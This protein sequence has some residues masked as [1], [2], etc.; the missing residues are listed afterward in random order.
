MGA[1][2]PGGNTILGPEA[3]PGRSLRLRGDGQ[4]GR[5]WFSMHSLTMLSG[6]PPQDP[7][8]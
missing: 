7:P 3:R 5:F 2:R 1:F 4:D 6:A 8:K